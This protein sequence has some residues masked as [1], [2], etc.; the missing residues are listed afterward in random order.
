M[1][2]WS[3]RLW[4]AV[5]LVVALPYPSPA[6]LIYTPGEGW[7]YETAGSNEGN[8]RR[9]RAKD[10]LVVAQEAFDKKDYSL[11][12][13]AAKRTVD[14][15]PLSDY[16]P[17][18]QYLVGRCYQAQHHDERAFKEYQKILDKFPR[19]VN[20]DEVLQRQYEITGQFLAG[21][22]FRVWDL[23]P[24]FPSMD[25]T[26]TM[27]TKIVKNGAYSSV[28]PQA[29]MKIGAAREKQKNY[30]EAVKAYERAADRYNDRPDVAAEALFRAG[31]AY[32]KQAE[33]A[34]Y[35]QGTAAKAIETFDEFKTLYPDDPRVGQTEKIEA[36]LRS[37]QARGN[38]KIAQYYEGHKKWAGAKVYYNQVLQK[39]PDPK[40]TYSTQARE[41]IDAINRIV[42]AASQ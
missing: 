18:A 24:L 23:I 41:R 4:L 3:L 34:E 9:T 42:P 17:Q 20:Y 19:F 7:Y 33:T 13:N 12:L 39:D 8:W 14:T 5:I 15:W 29:Q 38:F 22:W 21:E 32:Q 30:P 11:A 36:S 35:D 26:A 2:R 27:Y 1:N 31:V 16:A 10:Q 28:G 6:P 25:R 37:E 40:S